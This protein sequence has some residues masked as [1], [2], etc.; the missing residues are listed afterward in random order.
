MPPPRS[1]KSSESSKAHFPHLLSRI[2][3]SQKKQRLPLEP[4]KAVSLAA[5]PEKVGASEFRHMASC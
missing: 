3:C 1:D 5:M 2:T 4:G